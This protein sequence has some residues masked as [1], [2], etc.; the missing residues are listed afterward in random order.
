MKRI[1]KRIIGSKQNKP[2]HSTVSVTNQNPSFARFVAS[3]ANQLLL[4]RG[5]NEVTGVLVNGRAHTYT[6]IH[7][8]GGVIRFS[9]TEK[10]VFHPSEKGVRTLPHDKSINFYRLVIL[11]PSKTGKISPKDKNLLSKLVDR[12]AQFI[13]HEVRTEIQ[14]ILDEVS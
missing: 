9:A 1:W 8:E 4:I 6:R 5:V 7:Y 13:G 10:K 3:G 2:F 12:Y 14:I 11:Y